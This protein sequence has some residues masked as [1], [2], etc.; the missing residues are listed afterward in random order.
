MSEESAAA[1]ESVE[2]EEEFDPLIGFADEGVDS[3]VGGEP[4]TGD[5]LP[6]S[7]YRWVHAFYAAIVLVLIAT[8]IPIQFPDLLSSFIRCYGPSFS[9]VP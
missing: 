1:R 2:E 5:A 9:T 3:L 4:V 6:G 8:A 7:R